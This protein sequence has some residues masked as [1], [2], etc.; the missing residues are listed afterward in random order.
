MDNNAEPKPGPQKRESSRSGAFAGIGCIVGMGIMR[1][2]SENF[3]L[4]WRGR[5][6]GS[7]GWRPH[8]APHGR[9]GGEEPMSPN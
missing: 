3:L 2:Y 4:S 9:G 8:R 6:S 5:R 7:N 1:L